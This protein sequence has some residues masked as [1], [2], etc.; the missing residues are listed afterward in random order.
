MVLE[1]PCIVQKLIAFTCLLNAEEG[2]SL[3]FVCSGTINENSLV[4]EY[5]I[6]E[7]IWKFDTTRRVCKVLY[8]MGFYLGEAWNDWSGFCLYNF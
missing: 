3:F 1:C 5:V 2:N 8:E 6:L 7:R 4:G